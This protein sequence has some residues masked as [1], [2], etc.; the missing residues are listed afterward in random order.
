MK[1]S[2]TFITALFFALAVSLR[3]ADLPDYAP[4]PPDNPLKG[5]APYM[6]QARDF[7]HSLEFSYLPVNAV[8]KG[9]DVFDWQPLEE[10]VA[11]IAS[12]GRHAV[13]RFYLEYPNKPL[14]VPQFLVDAG[15]TIHTNIV[16]EGVSKER[17]LTPDYEDPR[18]RA[19]QA[20]RLRLDAL[21]GALVL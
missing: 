5:F 11:E 21:L 14:A 7:P 20:G 4:A 12:A 1:H 3:A 6:R 2:T 19:T 8:M 18:L 16:T 10:I 17:M 13:F 9:A 15:V